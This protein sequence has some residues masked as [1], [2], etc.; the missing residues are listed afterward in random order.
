MANMI[1]DVADILYG[2]YIRYDRMYEMTKYAFHGN[3]ESKSVNVFIDLYSILLS[4]YKR[5]DAMIQDQYSIASCII[6]LAIHIRAYFESRHRV[7]TKIY[8]VYGG[9]RYPEFP[10]NS[11]FHQLY[12]ANN[13]LMEDSNYNLRC[14]IEDNFGILELLCPYLFDIFFIRDDFTEFNSIV[15]YITE[16]IDTEKLPNVLY[17]KD[18]MS[19]QL[20]AYRPFTFLYRPKKSNN[21]DR[22][23]VVTKSTLYNAYRYG[24]LNT[25]T[26][27]DTTISP[28]LFSLVQSIAGVRTRSINSIKNIN[29]TIKLL[30]KSIASGYILDGYNGYDIVNNFNRGLYDYIN[31][32]NPLMRIFEDREIAERVRRNFIDIDYQNMYSR[33]I[34]SPTTNKINLSCVNL[35]SPDEVKAINNKYFRKYPLDLN[36]V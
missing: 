23:W 7:Y 12:N 15:G 5:P 34:Y 19:Y 11:Q 22:S 8:I 26:E 20:V 33:Y 30:E 21:E 24:E 17:S 4:L 6:N 25:K 28:Q 2:S 27:Y 10:A 18:L 3:I 9:T 14:V 13:I 1:P 32:A 29:T 16:I 36:R 31:E 35:Y